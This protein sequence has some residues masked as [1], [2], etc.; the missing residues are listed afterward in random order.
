VIKVAVQCHP[1]VL[2]LL[3]SLGYAGCREEESRLVVSRSETG[4]S[5]C[6]HFKP[7]VPIA[8]TIHSAQLNHID[9]VKLQKR[10][11]KKVLYPSNSR[12]QPTERELL[13]GGGRRDYAKAI[14]RNTHMQNK[15]H[16]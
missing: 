16:H 1:P 2:K 6:G 8:T 15:S 13:G 7:E 12:D 3:Q 4:K 5:C 9:N 11:L 10:V 14:S